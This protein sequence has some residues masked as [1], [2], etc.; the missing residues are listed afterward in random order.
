MSFAF[1]SLATTTATFSSWNPFT[2]D[3]MHSS[4]IVVFAIEIRMREHIYGTDPKP[5]T[6]HADRKLVRPMIAFLFF[7]GLESWMWYFFSPQDTRHP[8][9]SSLYKPLVFFFVSAKARDSLEALWRISLIVMRVLIVEFGLILAFASVACKMYGGHHESFHNLSTS[10]VRPISL[11]A[12][13][14]DCAPQF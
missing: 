3:S 1:Y 12:H 10:W 14:L 5:D 7:L 6:R 2:L 4:V 8:I 13:Y 11:P 9:F